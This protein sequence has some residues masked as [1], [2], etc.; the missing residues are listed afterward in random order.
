[1]RLEDEIRSHIEEETLDNIA[2]GMS[3]VAARSAALQKFGNVLQ[4]QEAARAVW[5]PVWLDQLVQDCHYALRSY[6]RNKLLSV[7]VVLTIALCIGMNTSLFSIMNTMLLR[8]LPYPDSTRLVA[9]TEGFTADYTGRFKTG[10]VGADFAGWRARAKSFQYLAG[11]QY[12]DSTLATESE[13]IRVRVVSTAGDF[14]PLTGT[15]PFLGRYF[16]GLD[17][18][19]VVILSHRVFVHQFGSARGVIGK[20]VLLGGRPVVIAGVLSP[21]FHFLFPQDRPGSTWQDVDVYLPLP[22]LLRGDRSRVFVVGK[23]NG[24][25]T[26][27]AALAELKGIET[28]NLQSFPDRWFSGVERMALQ[29][30]QERL[31]GTSGRGLYILQAA[32]IFVLLIACANIA[33]LLLART[34]SRQRELSIRLALGAGRGRVLRQ[35]FAEGLVLAVA[36]A[37]G[38]LLLAQ[39]L[40]WSM[41]LWAIK[42]IPRIAEVQMDARVLALTLCLTL[43]V[44]ILF[45]FGPATML[46]QLQKDHRRDGKRLFWIQRSLVAGE[47][48]LAL[49]LLAGAGL[50]MKSFLILHANVPGFEPEKTLVLQMSLTKPQYKERSRLLTLLTEI[51]TQTES[52][53]GVQ[54]SGICESQGYLLQRANKELPAIIDQFQ[55]GLVSPGYFAAMGMQLVA[56]RW[57]EAGDPADAALINETMAARVF[58]KRDPLGQNIEKLGRPVRVV[59]VVANLRYS[60]LDAEP[61]PE[62]F[63]GYRHNLSGLPTISIVARTKG[64]PMSIAAELRRR[65]AAIEAQES[66]HG[67]QTLSTALAD[68]IA[69]RRF[70]LILLGCFAAAAL[71]LAI[72]G[73]YGVVSYSVTQRTR[74][75]GLRLALG[76]KPWSIAAM[77][78]RQTM[79]FTAAGILIGLVG[80]YALTVSLS[81]LL[82]SVQPHDPVVLISVAVILALAAL[83][84]CALPT[85]LA[86]RVDPLISLRHD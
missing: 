73:I 11:Y 56:G 82:Y 55:E 10:I 64:D 77:L 67:V 76:A 52:L 13:S 66:I 54:F 70:H 75:I 26:P 63:R 9:Y 28:S 79:S 38:G 39:A 3:P 43:L 32:A 20:T 61:G 58:G 2:R 86:T 41:P 15:Q 53:P 48:A 78:I 14:W 23:L 6:N 21:D 85:A 59:G 5:I 68:S 74:E 31:A 81:S 7:S 84:A 37:L 35:F 33:N 22:P 44:A 50:M 62:L 47:L 29:P 8:P 34:A 4:V 12:Q 18:A 45:C 80:T 30:L 17:R 72:V 71:L 60:K 1:M 49:V 16:N 42:A 27:A 36:G 46:L 24:S 51:T 19:D 65:I 69:P 40:L 25:V 57:L 83:V